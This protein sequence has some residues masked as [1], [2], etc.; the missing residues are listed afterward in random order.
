M[1]RRSRKDLRTAYSSAM[2]EPLYL[3]S[4]KPQRRCVHGR[5]VIPDVSTHH[6][7]QALAYFGDGFMHASLKLGFQLV[8]LRLPPFAYRLPQ[9]REPSI[10][11][12]FT[13]IW[14]KPRKLNASGFP[15]PLQLSY[16]FC[17]H[18]TSPV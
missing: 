15:A 18:Y 17:I 3:E 12:F 6:R 9:H 14:V 10:A 2:P 16:E 4:E 5:S 1:R 7:L 8:Q 13:Q 11:L